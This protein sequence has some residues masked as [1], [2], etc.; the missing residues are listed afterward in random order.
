MA[1]G[2]SGQQEW[3]D[4]QT[5]RQAESIRQECAI[6]EGEAV[7]LRMPLEN[8]ACLS[9]CLSVHQ[10]AATDTWRQSLAVARRGERLGCVCRA[11]RS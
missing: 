7:A 10:W 2:R 4:G 11:G 6:A 9:V 5:D 3:A 8:Q 1:S